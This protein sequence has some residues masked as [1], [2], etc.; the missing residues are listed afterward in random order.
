M[1]NE[2]SQH[3]KSDGCID[4]TDPDVLERLYYDEGL[5]TVEIADRSEVTH[6]TVQYHM[7][8]N[9][10]DRRTVKQ[11]RRVE[12]AGVQM[13]PRGYMRWT[14]NYNGS[15]DRVY[16]HRLLAVAEHGFDAVA[17]NEVHHR[18]HIKW[19][20]RPDNIEVLSTAEHRR[21]H[22]DQLNG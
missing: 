19:D 14:S 2:D 18:N 22:I 13:M 21:E 6:Q 3:R 12:Y 5:S 10:I 11:S 1:S 7:E 8:K 4:H 20:N 15:Q 9:G 17:G 16:V